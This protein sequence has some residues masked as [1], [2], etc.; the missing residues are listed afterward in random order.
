M[1]ELEGVSF[2]YGRGDT[3]RQVSCRMQDGEV[4]GLI[5]P[6]GAG[7]STLLRLCAGLLKPRQGAVRVDGRSVDAYRVRAFARR[8]A[9]LPQSRPVPSISVQRLVEM[10]RF[11]H[12]TDGCEAVEQ[13]LSAVGLSENA[14][15]DVRTLS[16]G[17]RQMAYLAML[18]A[19]ESP[20]VLLD[21]PLTH[22]DIGAQLDVIRVIR[23]MRGQGK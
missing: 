12:G 6:N 7:K 16:G 18:L 21:E 23:Q 20:N 22:L 3:L 14:R 9:F 10:G 13:A 17:Q 5:G 4:V 11:A 1:I 15:R 2:G 8:V 19:Q